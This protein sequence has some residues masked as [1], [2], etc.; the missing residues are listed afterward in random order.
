MKT[1]F[2]KLTLSFLAM[3]CGWIACN[4]VWW[5][6]ALPG[7]TT[8]HLNIKDFIGIAAW[9]GIVVSMAWLALF[10]PVDL[11]TKDNSKLRR[12]PTAAWCGFLAAFYVVVA[13]F[14]CLLW[15]ESRRHGLLE[16]VWGMLDTSALPYVLG[17]CATGTVAA[18]ARALM[19]S[20][21]PRTEP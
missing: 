8:R 12:P 7:L 21:E 2:R 5:L 9:T 11:C 3:L 6:G 1:F 13:V 20:A 15:L 10:L 4:I 14:G 19:D 18:Y 16:S 17:T